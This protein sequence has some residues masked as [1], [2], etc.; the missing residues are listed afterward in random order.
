MDLPSLVCGASVG[1]CFGILWQHNYSGGVPSIRLNSTDL[2]T[3]AAAGAA[4]IR[5]LSKLSAAM[6]E[7]WWW[8]LKLGDSSVELESAALE[9]Q[10][11]VS[12][13]VDNSWELSNKEEVVEAAVR[14][15]RF[16]RGYS[17]K[18]LELIAPERLEH[19]QDLETQRLII[20]GQ[21]GGLY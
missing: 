12:I 5:A 14:L 2:S 18:L 16:H 8:L 20:S 11:I 1:C 19:L 21:R 7:S 4:A 9:L 15:R 6:D 17:N 10:L 13:C 3:Q